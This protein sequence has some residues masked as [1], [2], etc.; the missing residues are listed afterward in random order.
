M[1]K[2]FGIIML[3]VL[4]LVLV[5]VVGPCVYYGFIDKPGE[6]GTVDLPDNKKA[7]HTFY[8]ENTGGLILASNYEQHGDAAGKRLFVLHGFWEMRGKGFK[9]MAGDLTLDEN[10]FGKITVSQ[11]K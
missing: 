6:S 2:V 10:V 1:G 5:F 3:V 8:I 4:A 11:R 7:T 9:Y